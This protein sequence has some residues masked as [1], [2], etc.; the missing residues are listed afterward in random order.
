MCFRA[1]C[2]QRIIRRIKCYLKNCFFFLKQKIW[3]KQKW[4]QRNEIYLSKMITYSCFGFVSSVS[5]F[6]SFDS[7]I[8]SFLFSVSFELLFS[9]CF[10]FTI[11]IIGCILYT[12]YSKREEIGWEKWPVIFPA[13]CA[14][15]GRSAASP[16][17]K[18]QRN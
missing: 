11:G 18:R 7:S 6:S 13:P 3:M 12:L 17:V 1:S 2:T 16:S 10:S 9:F 5:C 4:K 15:C 14:C 8:V